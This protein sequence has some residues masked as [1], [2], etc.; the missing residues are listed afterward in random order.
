MWLIVKALIS[1]AVIVAV[2]EVS[3]RMPRMGHCF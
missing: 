3:S 2:A 1:A